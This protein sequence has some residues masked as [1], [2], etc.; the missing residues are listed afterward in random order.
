MRKSF[1]VNKNLFTVTAVTPLR[2][3]IEVY[4]LGMTEKR[5][6]LSLA[7]YNVYSFA[8]LKFITFT[9]LLN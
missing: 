2:F 6:H 1:E 3:V 5:R 4:N 7:L 8:L 9:T